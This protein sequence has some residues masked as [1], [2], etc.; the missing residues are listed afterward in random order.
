[1]ILLELNPGLAN[2]APVPVASLHGWA[3]EMTIAA[4]G[5]FQLYH[6]FFS[7][8]NPQPRSPPRVHPHRR[9]SGQPTQLLEGTTGAKCEVYLLE[10]SYDVE[11]GETTGSTI[12]GPLLTTIVDQSGGE[13]E[14]MDEDRFVSIGEIVASRG[15]NVDR[16]SVV[17]KVSSAG[18]EYLEGR[19]TLLLADAVRI[20]NLDR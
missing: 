1:M 19:A 10:E 18:A 13:T 3:M 20:E 15:C 17:V 2:P 12:S 9:T 11:T 5:S 4:S 8:S 14:T 6:T 16:L 7:H